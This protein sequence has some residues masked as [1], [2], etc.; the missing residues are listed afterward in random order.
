MP[1]DSMTA[2]PYDIA[3]FGATSFVGQILC[4]VLA[5]RLGFNGA[6]RW[7]I[8][9]RSPEK[10][11][12]LRE[13]LAAGEALLPGQ[14]ADV[15]DE[16]SLA[17]ICAKS[18]VVVST[19]GPY[20]LYGEPLVRACAAAGVDYCDLSG[21]P[22]WIRRMI[23]LY[24]AQA[25]ASGARLVPC[26]GFDSIPS[27]MGVYF[28]QQEARRRFG[29]PCSH[30]KMRVRAMRGGAS[31][32]TIA[33]MLNAIKELAGSGALRKMLA[34]PYALCPA[35]AAA[36]KTRQVSNSRPS[37]DPDFE[38]WIAPFLMAPVNTKI[39]HRSNALSHYSY[40]A[41]FRY[42]EAMLAKS[43]GKAYAI[44]AALGGFA[45]ASAIPPLRWALRGFV[46]P[47]PGEG[48][49]PEDR[50]KGFFDLRFLGKTPDGRSIRAKVTGDADP[51]YNS[52]S[53]MLAQAAI[54][55]ATLD[56]AE[57]PGGFYT[58]ASLFGDRLLAA[59]QANAGV[60]FETETGAAGSSA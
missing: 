19:V 1:S 39:V 41:G 16:A 57:A 56:G 29:Q 54:C 31:G 26:C 17:A 7:S 13:S 15:R 28:V 60:A 47:A 23:D 3:V 37:Y 36:A 30:V 14:I 48:P 35:D 20:A 53:K 42:D 10:L 32:G 11:R 22:L 12:A 38:A 8:A 44:A 2:K 34:N 5:Q 40:G 25:Q 49:A 59:L 45:A 18:R 21:E 9:G 33:S 58:P 6:L 50:K 27:D 4:R 55:L 51:G 24:E 52:T 43:R 46:L